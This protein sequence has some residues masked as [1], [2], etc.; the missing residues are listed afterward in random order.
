MQF[1]TTPTQHQ[2]RQRQLQTIQTQRFHILQQLDRRIQSAIDCHNFTLA[3][4][5]AA[6]KASLLELYLNLE[7]GRNT[8][9][10]PLSECSIAS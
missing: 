1:I 9:K 4:Q 2:E 3:D 6:E 7:S 5:L 8:G 10:L